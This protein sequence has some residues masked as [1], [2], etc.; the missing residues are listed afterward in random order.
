MGRIGAK[1]GDKARVRKWLKRGA[2]VN[3]RNKAGWTAL[4]YA[5]KGHH[6]ELV[7]YLVSK[8]ADVNALDKY[9]ESAAVWAATEGHFDTVAQLLAAG[10]DVDAANDDGESLL[11]LAVIYGDVPAVRAV[12]AAGAAV[13]SSDAKGWTPLVRA[14]RCQY[15][16]MV[17]ELVRARASL[18][19]TDA[20]G[21]TPL[22]WASSLGDLRA[23]EFLLG[24]G[25]DPSATAGP[26]NVTPYDV[27]GSLEVK[28]FLQAGHGL[29]YPSLVHRGSSGA[30]MAG[31]AYT[32]LQVGG[33]EAVAVKRARDH[34]ARAAAARTRAQHET[35]LLS[36]LHASLHGAPGGPE[37][38]PGGSAPIRTGVS[39]E[40]QARLAAA[41]RSSSAARESA[42]VAA[43]SAPA[44]GAALSLAQAAAAG[45]VDVI[46]RLLDEGQAADEEDPATG[47]TPLHFAA[48]AGHAPA[49]Q[50]LTSRGFV[51]VNRVGE[52][53]VTPLLLASAAG[54][55]EAAD[56]LVAHSAALDVFDP[57]DECPL[58]HAA[59]ANNFVK[60]Q[61]LA[62]LGSPVDVIDARGMSPIHWA[63]V[64][65]SRDM[66]KMLLGAGL[67][68]NDA[69]DDGWT[70]LHHA[71]YNDRARLVTWLLRHGAKS[72]A[73]TA[74]GE[75]PAD[76]ASASAQ[77]AIKNHIYESKLVRAA[78]DAKDEM[79]KHL[80]DAVGVDVNATNA[81]GNSALMY[82][83]MYENV[84]LTQFLL[85]HGADPSVMNT[86]E[87]TPLWFAAQYAD[88]QLSL[89]LA[90]ALTAA[91]AAAANKL[92]A[93]YLQDYSHTDAQTLAYTSDN[94]RDVF[95]YLRSAPSQ[96]AP[97]RARTDASP[98]A[99]DDSIMLHPP[100][101]VDFRWS[102]PL[103][104][105]L[106]AG[107]KS[108]NVKDSAGETPLFYAARTG[109]LDLA[110]EMLLR[111][112]AASSVNDAGQTPAN[113]AAAP[114][115]GDMLASSARDPI[116]VW[117][118][119][120]K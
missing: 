92:A 72:G 73:K 102:A 101:R 95:V 103:V 6:N 58:Q 23:V 20:K 118:S 24:A 79:V 116:H 30:A 40:L 35:E 76:V 55:W 37:R 107:R 32:E 111:G 5:A 43:S 70:V 115:L 84:E 114:A 109:D 31:S 81:A 44:P 120:S 26:D 68:I 97:R 112:A 61:H 27:A 3:A 65:G 80:V 113:V 14:I 104:D 39:A 59:R 54:H 15:Y 110:R 41:Y 45:R 4:M 29:K 85:A 75:R 46:H 7:E 12:L 47:W 57:N 88:P 78:E 13:D 83:V 9:N 66:V 16:D 34:A 38:A 19:V 11:A 105:Y 36:E 106:M 50:A 25:A 86:D 21:W 119:K 74:S 108:M 98:A 18:A 42:Q 8:G 87:R 28:L 77:Q 64:H 51:D 48:Q 62:S 22:H 17:R 90:D 69:D 96:F 117:K 93:V 99:V 60:V 94:D 52:P 2:G 82:A 67:G 63:A 56:V 1:A 71:A 100:P 91:H 89:L 33:D 49:L 10:A 53:G